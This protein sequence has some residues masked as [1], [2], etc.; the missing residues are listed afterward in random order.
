[1]SAEISAANRHRAHAR[2]VEIHGA[3]RVAGNKLSDRGG[4]PIALSGISLFWSQ[5]GGEFYTKAWIDWVVRTFRVDVVRAALGITEDGLL[6]NVRGELDKLWRVIDAAISADIYLIVDWHAAGAYTHEACA[7]FSEVA[8]RYGRVPN[9]IFE[10]W[11]EPGHDDWL[12]T[13]RPHHTAVI[14]AV[15]LYSPEALV[16]C[17]TPNYCRDVGVAA[18]F[19]VDRS[20]VCY[21]LH[22]YAGTHRQG[23]RD[24]ACDALRAGVCLFASEYGLG[25]SHGDGTIDLAEMSRWWQF[26]EEHTISHVN[27]SLVD[28]SEACAAL[29]KAHGVWRVLGTHRLSRSGRAVRR[30][31][32][33]S[34]TR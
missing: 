11:N 10:T 3:L 17:G 6:W 34:G 15:R 16:I 28:K 13:V 4:S 9:L 14:D 24:R 12:S 32:R 20:N 5:W 26:L 8:Q 23:L 30:H 18:E 2:A 25:E 33:S 19:P 31:L 22:F 21:A 29:I 7:V 1:M 27:W